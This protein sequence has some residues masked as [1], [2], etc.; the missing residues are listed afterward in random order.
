MP[1][2]L[3]TIIVFVPFSIMGLGLVTLAV[4]WIYDLIRPLFDNR[5]VG[6]DAQDETDG[7]QSQP[8]R[9]T[10]RAGSLPQRIVSW[11]H[12][13]FHNRIDD[14]AET[15]DLD[16][17]TTSLLA[18]LPEATVVIND[19]DEVIRANPD[20]YTLGVVDDESIISDEV[21]D[22]VREVRRVGGRKQFDLTTHTREQDGP[23]A[24]VKV[25]G[26]VRPNWLKV[27]VGKVGDFVVVLIDDVSEAIRFAQVRDSFISNVS[28][29]LI[30]PSQALEQLADSLAND[31]LD[32]EQVSW[33]AHQVR[34]S[35]DRL[36]RMVADLMLLIKAQ[37]PI[38]PSSANRLNM[39]EQVRLACE[40]LHAESARYDVSV[41]ISG[42]DSLTVNGDAEQ[43]VAAI[44][45]L[46][47]N[48][49]VYS[50]AG[51]TVNIAVSK[52][53]NGSQAAVEVVDQGVG[54]AKDE[55]TR[56]FERFYRGSNQTLRSRDGIGLGLA[57][58]KHVALT[59]HG[60]VTVWSVPGSGSTF[61][62]SLP[63]A[64]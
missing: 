64:Q 44:S 48:A 14:D 15:E 35:C 60:N 39:M 54:I 41:N 58:V 20:A 46:V 23:D 42:D 52:S 27:T 3:R 62:F 50:P 24:S 28:E 36:N 12:A 40:R 30:K 37:E 34:S 43:V 21:R 29:Q 57:I 61:T 26:V 18:M 11:F 8:D 13:L 10:D 16:P 19:H 38:A 47:Q 7:A 59:H 4:F 49:L 56:I 32:A 6:K 53:E 17:D 51:G 25:R 63:L 55:Q 22:A 45:K 2:T 31:A 1:E 33:H 5:F 9:G